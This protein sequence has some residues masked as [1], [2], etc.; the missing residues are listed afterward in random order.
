MRTTLDNSPSAIR[1]STYWILICA[2][3]GILLG[4]V[5]AVESVDKIGLE[6]DRL[7][8]I[9]RD[10]A[11]AKAS[12]AKKGIKGEAFDK[13]LKAKEESIRRDSQLMRPFLGANDRSRWCTIRALVEPEMR[14]PGAPYAIEKVIQEPNWD[15]IDMVKHNGHLYSS[16]PPFGPTLLAGAYWVI[17]HLTGMSLGTHP[18]AV[19][20]IMLILFNVVP[21][22]VTFVLLAK[23]VERFGTTDWGRLFAMAAAVFGTFLTTFAVT[24]NNHL[25]AAACA[26]GFLYCA[27]PI[28]FDGERRLRYFFGAGFAC[29]L[30]A[31]TELP[32]LAL[33]TAVGLAFFWK[34]PWRTLAAYLPAAVLVPIPFFATNYIAY[35]TLELAYS[36]RTANDEWYHY[37]YTRNGIE[38]KSYWDNPAG[39]DRGEPSVAV[40]AFNVLIGH[41]GIFSLTPIW[42]L[43]VLG[44]FYWLRQSADRKLR[45]LALLIGAIS[46]VCTGYFIFWQSLPNRNYGGVASGFRWVFWLAPLW[47]LA[48]LPA[49]DVCARTR[50][51]RGLALVLLTMSALSAAYPIWNPWSNPWLADVWRF[52]Q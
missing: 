11:L 8:H 33:L 42:L 14:V 28:W 51:R 37:T 45:E 46:L 48:L 21:L 10:I 44:T 36:H 22:A 2:G 13:A 30:T 19:G 18:F 26:A 12:L 27:V 32:A 40:Y 35:G 25:P 43:S 16:K 50:W 41:H 39:V 15:T 5:L 34:D 1:S 4:R 17:L 3:V 20:R 31:A 9:D 7:A 47:I 23:L 6:K 29:A 38:Y 24:L 52:L 49:A